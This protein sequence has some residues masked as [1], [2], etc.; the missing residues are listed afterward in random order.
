MLVLDNAFVAAGQ[1]SLPAEL[2]ADADL[3]TLTAAGAGEL[4]AV[5]TDSVAFTPLGGKRSSRGRPASSAGVAAVLESVAVELQ[6]RGLVAPLRRPERMMLA[7]Y[8]KGGFYKP[9]RDNVAQP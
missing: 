7:K 5:R 8:A 2:A 6:E 4:A 3:L 9:H 1:P